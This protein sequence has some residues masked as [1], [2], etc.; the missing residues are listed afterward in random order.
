MR[1]SGVIEFDTLERHLRALR[2]RA[3][4]YGDGRA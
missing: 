2:E 1:A 4:D 3:V